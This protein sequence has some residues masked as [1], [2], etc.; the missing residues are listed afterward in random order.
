MTD[1]AMRT[2]GTPKDSRALTPDLSGKRL[3]HLPASLEVSSPRAGEGVGAMPDLLLGGS[4]VTVEAGAGS[5][6]SGQYAQPVKPEGIPPS[7]QSAVA[8]ERNLVPVA[9]A[10][11]DWKVTPRRIRHL[12]STGRLEGLQQANGYWML[13][14]TLTASLSEHGEQV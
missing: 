4:A 1:R 7:C 6:Q 9:M 10:A 11:H 12:L 2:E 5:G 14:P 13:S 3:Y 8:T